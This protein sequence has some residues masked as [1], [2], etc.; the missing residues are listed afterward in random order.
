MTTRPIFFARV[1][2]HTLS[3]LWQRITG[4]SIA[5]L[6]IAVLAVSLT[7]WAEFGTPRSLS[8]FG[9]EWLRD[10]FIKLKVTTEEERRVLVVDIDEASLK[11]KGPWPWPRDRIASL[12]EHLLTE[13]GARGVALDIVL[14]KPADTAGDTR[15]ALLAANGPVVLAQA[16]DYQPHRPEPLR[17][18]VLRLTVRA[19]RSTTIR[20]S[21][22][23]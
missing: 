6:L 4:A 9:N 19:T 7:V 10:S 20:R 13:Y 16:F 1:T 15:L 23:C 14:P 11:R 18:G 3:A 17:E 8:H 2:L 22:T 5:R 12:V 21:S